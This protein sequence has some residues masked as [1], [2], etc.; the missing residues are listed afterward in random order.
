MWC[1]HR[2]LDDLARWVSLTPTSAKFAHDDD[3]EQFF[4]SLFTWWR[5]CG[6]MCRRWQVSK[7]IKISD[8][9]KI[10]IYALRLSFLLSFL[11]IFLQLPSIKSNLKYKSL[12]WL[13]LRAS[14]NL[15]SLDKILPTS[16]QHNRTYICCIGTELLNWKHDLFETGNLLGSP[17]RWKWSIFQPFLS[18]YKSHIFFP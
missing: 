14:F 10:V 2:W 8:N 12:I 6:I 18:S 7:F 16:V 17:F 1:G 5:C 9:A 3:D 4:D 15:S 11:L 13:Q